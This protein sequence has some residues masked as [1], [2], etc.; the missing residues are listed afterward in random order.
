MTLLTMPRRFS[1]ARVNCS[2][3]A[4]PKL[5][6]AVDR[7]Q[8]VL[9]IA[10][11]VGASFTH[12]LAQAKVQVTIPLRTIECVVVGV[13]AEDLTTGVLVEAVDKMRYEKQR[14]L[15]DT[16][17]GRIMS[18]SGLFEMRDRKPRVVDDGQFGSRPLK[19]VYEQAL[20]HLKE[21]RSA[22]LALLT[23]QIYSG[24]LFFK[25]VDDLKVYSG[26]CQ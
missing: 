20:T 14:F 2:P 16:R 10:T 11:A 23:V 6:H 17:S 15:L 4:W 18:R 9:A 21:T 22:D 13:Q 12:K 7:A 3:L 5:M 25:L 19:V 1:D 8:L 26:T 24:N